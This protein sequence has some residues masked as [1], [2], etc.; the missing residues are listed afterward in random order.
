MTDIKNFDKPIIR[1]YS[2][3]SKS[4]EFFNVP[5]CC[6]SDVEA[7]K[8]VKELISDERN[9]I[10]KNTVD[11]ELHSVGGFDTGSGI[12]T[13]NADTFLVSL[14]DLINGEQE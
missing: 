3:K 2:I 12:F 4:L 8:L 9:P 11:L 5:F 10:S 14:D 6:G 1:F 7:V 13:N